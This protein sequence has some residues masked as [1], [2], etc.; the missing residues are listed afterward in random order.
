[1]S[2]KSGRRVVLA[3]AAVFIATALD[4]LT[5]AAPATQPSP[6]EQLRELRAKVADQD[7]EILKLK[8]QVAQKDLL[9]QRLQRQLSM[10]PSPTPLQPFGLPLVPGPQFPQTPWRQSDPGMPPGSV[11]QRF[12]GSTFYLV[13]LE[14]QALRSADATTP[15]QGMNWQSTGGTS[16]LKVGSGEVQR[17][18]PHVV[19][20]GVTVE[21][22]TTP[23]RPPSRPAQDLIDDR[24]GAV[25]K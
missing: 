20:H 7:R 13:P 8:S 2:P 11:P 4:R 25:G 9:I 1:M 18:V 14:G 3:L 6:E 5:T 16:P 19:E 15:L 24:A 22:A 21:P 10:V 23:V 17:G 12:N